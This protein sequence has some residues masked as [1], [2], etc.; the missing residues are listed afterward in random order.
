MTGQG[1]NKI[2]ELMNDSYIIADEG[3]IKLLCATVIAN[4][5][6]KAPVWLMVV[7]GSGTGKTEFLMALRKIKGYIPISEL[8]VNTFI[9]GMK[10]NDV[11]T[12]LLATVQRG[13]IMV[14]K[15]FTTL[16]SLHKDV[17]NALMGQ[18]RDIYDGYVTKRF[19]NGLQLSFEPKLGFIGASTSALFTSKRSYAAMGERFIIYFF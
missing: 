9:S 2:V 5:L 14:F 15:D 12:S 7:A 18:L 3:I 1:Y 19:G 8:T 4:R 10:R 16:L 11:E 13:D 6:P 17:R